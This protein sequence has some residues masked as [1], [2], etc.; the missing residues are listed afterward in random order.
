ME[1]S[2][3]HVSD[4]EK[5]DKKKS[6]GTLCYFLIFLQKSLP[7]VG[8]SP[9]LAFRIFQRQK[10]EICGRTAPSSGPC[11][12]GGLCWGRLPFSSRGAAGR[13]PAPALVLLVLQ[14]PVPMR[15]GWGLMQMV[16]CRACSQS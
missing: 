8:Y 16:G 1:A 14:L 2:T 12:P 15:L 3:I 9:V 6:S 4:E 13:D 7:S 10:Y 5:A 11:H